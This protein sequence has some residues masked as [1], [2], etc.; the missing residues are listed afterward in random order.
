MATAVEN[1]AGFHDQTWRVNFAG[2]DRFGLNF[3][4]SGSFYGAVEMAPDNYVI[5]VNLALDFRMFAED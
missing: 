4:F 5:A 3:D 1:G 2:D